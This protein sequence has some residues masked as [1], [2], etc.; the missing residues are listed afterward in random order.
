MVGINNFEGSTLTTQIKGYLSLSLMS[1]RVRD[2]RKVLITKKMGLLK[3]VVLPFFSI[4]HAF[5]AVI[6]LLGR[7]EYLL[8]DILHYPESPHENLTQYEEHF[9]GVIAGCHMAFLFGCL[10]GIFI[11]HG[12]YRATV[13]AMELIYCGNAGYDAM[14]LGCPYELPFALG[15]LAAVGLVAHA[16][17]PGLFT[18]DKNKT[19]KH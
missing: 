2:F 16:F 4:L 14:R 13:A 1:V 18:K 6:I 7:K 10:M 9:L 15:G 19:K 8:K 17:E 12:H 3:H 5:L 11:E